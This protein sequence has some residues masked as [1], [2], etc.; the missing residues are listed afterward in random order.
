MVLSVLQVWKHIVSI[1]FNLAGE[2]LLV[3]QFAMAYRLP[4][5]GSAVD[6]VY[7]QNSAFSR[8]GPIEFDSVYLNSSSACNL[9]LLL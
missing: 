7:D 3:R 8:K 5:E 4:Y 1:L 2:N 6:N 9:G